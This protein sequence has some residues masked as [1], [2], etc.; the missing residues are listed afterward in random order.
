M[1]T[2]KVVSL[3]VRPLQASHL[4][5]EVGGILGESNTQLGAPVAAFDF[6]TFYSTLG[7]FP[8]ISGDLSRLLFD[9]LAI[10]SF[11]KPS[12]LVALR[13]EAAKAA[14]NNAINAR[15][16]AYFP[17]YGNAADIITRINEDYSTALGGTKPLRLGALT[18]L[19]RQHVDA[20]F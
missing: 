6:A 12:T 8:T 5:F 13:A 4:C 14:L 2:A 3:C 20:R 16:N 7:S 1:A 17:K 19:P 18:T 9:P 10:Q 15:Q 11:V